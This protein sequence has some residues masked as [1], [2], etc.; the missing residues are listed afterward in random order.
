MWK[1][2]IAP[3]IM[4]GSHMPSASA[5]NRTTCYNA[6]SAPDAIITACSRLAKSAALNE[7]DRR[8]AHLFRG[9]GYFRSGN[10]QPAVADFD[11]VLRSE[12]KNANAM[13]W[14]SVLSPAGSI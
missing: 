9:V 8:N 13:N 10:Y 1:W 5:D 7:S 6:K 14:R 2:L 11:E 12:P 4:L 3:A